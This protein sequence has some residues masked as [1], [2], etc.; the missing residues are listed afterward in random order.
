M[1]ASLQSLDVE[2]TFIYEIKRDVFWRQKSKQ[3]E[4]SLGMRRFRRGLLDRHGESARH[5]RGITSRQ[6]RD[7]GIDP[8]A[9]IVKAQTAPG[10]AAVRA[11]VFECQ[12]QAA[13]RP[14]EAQGA[15][16]IAPLG[17]QLQELRGDILVQ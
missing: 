17:A 10:E 1:S 15:C 12:R 2:D 4:Q 5:A 9:I 11:G 13:E 6:P 8:P 7:V 16:R 14:G 3:A